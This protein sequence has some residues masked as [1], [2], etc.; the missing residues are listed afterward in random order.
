VWH[1]KR[2]K[3]WTEIE[4][5]SGRSLLAIHQDIH[6]KIQAMNLAAMVRNVA[7][8]VADRRFDHCKHRHQVRACSTL[9]EMKHNLVRL[10]C[11][12][13][14]Q[15]RELLDTFN[16]IMAKPFRWTFTGKTVAT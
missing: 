15:R 1:C 4:N 12:D 11:S 3:R 5:F 7:Q 9:S 14:A 10:L 6:A 13:P 16:E 8:F 2:Q